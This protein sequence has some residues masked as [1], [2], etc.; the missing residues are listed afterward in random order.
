MRAAPFH[1][2]RFAVSLPAFP[3]QIEGVA[4]RVLKLAIMVALAA[5]LIPT[6]AS[7]H[8]H[9]AAARHHHSGL[10]I[11]TGCVVRQT[12][13]GPVAVSGRNADRL[14]GAINA[15]WAAGFRGPVNCAAPV[16]THVR[17]SL[18]YTGDACDM[19]QTGWGRSTSRLMYHAG[20]ILARFGLR[21]GCSFRD[22]G[23]IDTGMAFARAKVR[24][25]ER[26]AVYASAWPRDDVYRDRW[27]W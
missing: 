3:K 14:V 16:G 26:Q 19:A 20:A 6:A 21:D 17:H 15:L 13:V 4:M 8:R 5:V 25:R 23:H 9:H 2:T 22:C 27:R 24:Q 10:Y 11:C 7:A 12:A 18:H 1:F